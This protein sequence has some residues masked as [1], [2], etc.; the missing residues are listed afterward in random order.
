MGRLKD[1]ACNGV[2]GSSW[3]VVLAEIAPT[4]R[5]AQG[6]RDFGSFAGAGEND[7]TTIRRRL[8]SAPLTKE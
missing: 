1:N 3:A 7:E 6:E 8:Y 5:Q 4:L 2:G